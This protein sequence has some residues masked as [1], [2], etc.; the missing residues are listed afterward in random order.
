MPYPRQTP[1]HP[2]REMNEKSEKK[3]NKKTKRRLVKACAMF[4]LC[5]DAEV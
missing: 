1:A 3:N 2:A 4:R 5:D